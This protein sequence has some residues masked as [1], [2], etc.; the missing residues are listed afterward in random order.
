MT[1][2]PELYISGYYSNLIQLNANYD[3][4]SKNRVVSINF[5]TNLGL[6]DTPKV[7]IQ[8]TGYTEIALASLGIQ[9]KRH[10]YTYLKSKT[11]AQHQA[12][13]IGSDRIYSTG[14]YGYELSV[15]GITIKNNSLY[16]GY[17]AIFDTLGHLLELT[18]ADQ[19]LG[20]V[21]MGMVV[22][23]SYGVPFYIGSFY[24]KNNSRRGYTCI[25]M[26]QIIPETFSS[27]A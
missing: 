19:T 6:P 1:K 9:K 27:P 22:E 11:N 12:L 2:R 8:N 3:P 26:G 18:Q 24:G 5:Q 7:L 14:K 23:N 4:Q 15:E 20:E 16:N 21:Q 17:I 10:W 13:T 25:Q